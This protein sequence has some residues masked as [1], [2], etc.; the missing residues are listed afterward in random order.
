MLTAPATPSG[1]EPK[2]GYW[3]IE[4]SLIKVLPKVTSLHDVAKRLEWQ[5][6]LNQMLLTID[7][8]WILRNQPVE[9]PAAKKFQGQ[10]TRQ[11]AN[12]FTP[13]RAWQAKT[14]VSEFTLQGKT[15]RTPNKLT[16]QTEPARRDD[17]ALIAGGP[18]IAR[19][20]KCDSVKFGISVR[21]S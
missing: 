4:D 15:Y 17:P 19:R 9:N 16:V 5:E 7:G 8:L 18:C 2:L 21:K 12:V 11:N 10:S 3:K 20:H 6:A 14:P 1:Y 13:G